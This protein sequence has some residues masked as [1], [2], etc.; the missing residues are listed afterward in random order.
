MGAS[1]T[2]GGNPTSSTSGVSYAWTPATALDN[3]VS[4]NPVS[5]P[6]G[7][8]TYT[9]KVTT[10]QGCSVSDSVLITV[11]PGIQIPDGITPNGDG[12][13][14]EWIISGIQLFP[15]CQV[16]VFNRWGESLFQ[17]HGYKDRWNGTY[18]GKPLPV[19]TYYYVI[20]LK[21]PLYPNAFT[22]PLTI[23]R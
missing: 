22:G 9:V 4:P 10:P 13:N 7:T 8:V 20:D 17:S 19:G 14:D 5:T 1:V 23:V 21:D 18:K 16:E 6:A 11:L 3:P 15:D 12:K 2:L